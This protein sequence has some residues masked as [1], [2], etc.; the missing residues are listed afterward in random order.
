MN[1]GEESP[2]SGYGNGSR[3]GGERGNREGFI[4]MV[5]GE[6]DLGKKTKNREERERKERE[7]GKKLTEM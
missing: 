4:T 2:R 5:E 1:G 3:L 7:S 6:D